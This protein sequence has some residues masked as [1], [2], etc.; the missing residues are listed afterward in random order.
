MSDI[1]EKQY[2]ELKQDVEDAKTEADKAKGAL[3]ATIATLKKD[4]DVSNLKEAKV[5]L[6]KFRKETETAQLRFERSLKEYE[7]RWRDG[8]A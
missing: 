8:D 3:E 6:A 1:T 4:Y 2:R 7:R 5:K